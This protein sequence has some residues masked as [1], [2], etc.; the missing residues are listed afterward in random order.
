MGQHAH[1]VLLAHRVAD[2]AYVGAALHEQ[3]EQRLGRLD[4]ARLRDRREI[5]ADYALLGGRG[6]R[7]HDQVVVARVARDARAELGADLIAS[8]GIHESIEDRAAAALARRIREED[9][10]AGRVGGVGVGIGQ[11]VE[12]GGA[13]ALDRGDRHG[14]LGPV[15]PAGRLQVADLDARAAL[16]ADAQRFVD[17][18]EQPGLL[19]ADVRGVELSAPREHARHR[20][21][22]VGGRVAAGRVLQAARE[23]RRSL[24]ETL[25]EHVQHALELGWRQRAVLEARDGPPQRPLAEQQH[26]VGRDAVRLERAEVGRD[27][28]PAFAGRR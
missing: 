10:Q 4:T 18:F 14:L 9:R 20:D 27:V 15:G 3:L 12:A 5:L 1:D 11:H 7:D 22:L 6:A 26:L 21:Q 28:V 17:R 23:A 24:L 16:A 25:L 13:R 2:E 19:V 8:Q